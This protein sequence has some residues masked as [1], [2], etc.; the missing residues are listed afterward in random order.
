M[1]GRP[2]GQESLI[3]TIEHCGLATTKRTVRG[4]SNKTPQVNTGKKTIIIVQEIKLL[5]KK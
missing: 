2:P 5:Y 1:Q 3:G 4:E